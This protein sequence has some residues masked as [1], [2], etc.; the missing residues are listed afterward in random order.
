[1]N[2]KFKWALGILIVSVFAYYAIN[3]YVNRRAGDEV[4][5]IYFADRITAAHEKLIEIYNERNKG[6]VRIVPI[7]FPNFDFS[8]NERKEVLARSLRGTGDGIDLFAVDIIW[9]QRFAKWG[10]SLDKYLTEEEKKRLLPLAVES[11]YYNGELVAVPLVLV[12]SICYYRE[13]LVETLPNGKEMINKFDSTNITWEEFLDYRSQYKGDKPFYIFPAADYEGMI[14][15]FMEFLL[16]QNPNYFQQYGFNL[17][18]PEAEKALQFMVDLIYKYNATPP[19]VTKFTE[20]SSYEY[21]I[22][23]DGFVI[24]G[25]PT[26]DMDFINEAYDKEKQSRLKKMW[27]PYFKGGVPTSIVGGWDLMVSKFSTKKKE[28]I[29]FLKFLL[30]DEAQEIFYKL[31]GHYPVIKRFY[32]DPSY[33]SKYP[34][35]PKIKEYLKTAKH[36]PAHPDYTRFSKIMSYYIDE[37]LKNRISVKEALIKATNA[38]QLEKNILQ[39]R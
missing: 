29:D 37:A 1:M 3:Y 8:T 9:V 21:F 28:T 4:I 30:S 17:D 7:D 36:R 23:N 11:C 16:S 5:E 6:K 33:L 31:S 18:R 15:N 39:E 24:H 2:T 22:N 32:E 34:E 10:E 12:N 27:I 26:Y 20:I 14:C 38:I 19:D 13:D 35:I 25:W